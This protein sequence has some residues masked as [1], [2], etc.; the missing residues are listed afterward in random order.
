[1]LH[2]AA[3]QARRCGGDAKMVAPRRIFVASMRF[4]L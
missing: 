1:M 4:A 2:F 3:A